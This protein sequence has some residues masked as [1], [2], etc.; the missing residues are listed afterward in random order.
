MAESSD[1][2]LSGGR[3]LST[4]VA[5]AIAM[6][7]LAVVAITLSNNGVVSRPATRDVQC[8]NNVRNLGLALLNYAL[9]N[10][11]KLLPPASI[12]DQKGA[13]RHSWR[14]A[15]TGF[16]DQPAFF[17]KYRWDESW[18]SSGNSHLTQEMRVSGFHCPSDPDELSN[19]S[20]VVVVGPH[21]LFPGTRP[22]SLNDIKQPGGAAKTIL[23][24]ELPRSGVHWTEP[25][26]LKFE[27][28]IRGI[29]ISGEPVASVH[30]TSDASNAWIN[31]CFADG[32]AEPVPLKGFGEFVSE[33]A[34]I[35]GQPKPS[36]AVDSP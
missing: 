16:L 29:G 26:D 5:W 33:H 35:D 22:R 15:I 14:V 10:P 20:F 17:R 13:V 3:V 6:L 30:P 23:V 34:W 11:A 8:L 1:R 36:P 24:I 19:T 12:A 25:R 27:D 9:T 31:V 21:T 2:P 4:I 18:N 7:I 28:A 32:H